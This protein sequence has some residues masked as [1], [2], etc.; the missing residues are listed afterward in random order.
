MKP[1]RNHG[2]LI[3]T[4]AILIFGCSKEPKITEVQSQNRLIGDWQW[5]KTIDA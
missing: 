5:I 2:L 4:V 1:F 3:L